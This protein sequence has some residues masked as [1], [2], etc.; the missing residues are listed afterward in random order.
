MC[1]SVRLGAPLIYCR[2]P[3]S[4]GEFGPT[5]TLTDFTLA[6]TELWFLHGYC[7]L[8]FF[9]GWTQN[10]SQERRGQIILI[11]VK[12]SQQ[13][14]CVSLHLS[15]SALLRHKKP[16]WLQIQLANKNGYPCWTE[17][18]LPQRC[19]FAAVKDFLPPTW[20]GNRQILAHE[21]KHFLFKSLASCGWLVFC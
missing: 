18:S 11:R 8:V 4:H 9:A 12:N 5:K 16:R 2:R 14:V 1:N 21:F 17:I 6:T 3:Q 7:S 20:V 13:K 10:H 15:A 19:G